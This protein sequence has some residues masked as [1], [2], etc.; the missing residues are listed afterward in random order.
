MKI[1]KE[2]YRFKAK[3]ILKDAD[4]LVAYGMSINFFKDM[5][6]INDINYFIQIMQ[7]KTIKEK[8]EIEE[9]IIH[10]TQK[11]KK[12]DL[13]EYQIVFLA[14]YHQYLQFAL[15]NDV[16][17]YHNNRYCSYL[18]S[19][20]WNNLSSSDNPEEVKFINGKTLSQ[21][22]DM[23]ISK[24]NS[25]M[26]KIRNNEE[27]EEKDKMFLEEIFLSM[28]YDSVIY[29]EYDGEK[30]LMYDI[31]D[32]FKKYPINDLSTPRN[33][34]LSIL[35]NLSSRMIEIPENCAIQFSNEYTYSTINKTTTSGFYTRTSEGVPIICINGLD[36]YDLRTES[37]F[38]EKMFVIFHELGHLNQEH[39]EFNDEFKKVIDMEDYLIQNDREFYDKYHDSFCLEW[40]ADNYA[41]I[42]MIEAYG[43]QYPK[44]VTDI[45]TNQQS[46]KRI[47]W[48]TFYLMELEEYG[49]VSIKHENLKK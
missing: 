8:Q 20:A 36:T 47:D 37:D 16:R 5:S 44:I 30:D 4:R 23:L 32:Y 17:E 27:I 49:K 39:V 28:A 42:Q 18:Y 14:K 25:I 11:V 1:I 24:T 2:D 12:E 38:L 10:L 40:D 33:M 48:P 35:C 31:V 21:I 26:D 46:R 19:N 15:E 41:T 7:S 29:K 3:K 45:V 22:D 43:E 6:Q 13:K 34:Q 9:G